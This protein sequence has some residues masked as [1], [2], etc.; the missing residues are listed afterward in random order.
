MKLTSYA[1]HTRQYAFQHAVDAL[2]MAREYKRSRDFD[3][4]H[5]VLLIVK[6]WRNEAA[7]YIRKPA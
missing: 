4:L 2:N 7:Y 3:A 6:F 5:A 1:R